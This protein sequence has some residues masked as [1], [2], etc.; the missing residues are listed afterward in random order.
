VQ[1][2]KE[3][4]EFHGNEFRSQWLDEDFEPVR[5]AMTRLFESLGWRAAQP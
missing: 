5:A 2:A 3:Q 4:A 1:L